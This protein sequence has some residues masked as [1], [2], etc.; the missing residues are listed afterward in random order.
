MPYVTKGGGHTTLHRDMGRSTGVDWEAEAGALG[1]LR[2]LLGFRQEWQGRAGKQFGIGLCDNPLGLGAQ[3]HVWPWVILGRRT[4][5]GH[6]REGSSGG[7]SGGRAEQ[8]AVCLAPSFVSGRQ[9][10][11]TESK[12]TQ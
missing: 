4:S 2:P 6:M 9:Q 8:L 7:G 5:A 1:R 10:T 12:K 11:N 3:K